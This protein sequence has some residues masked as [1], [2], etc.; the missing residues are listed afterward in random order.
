MKEEI[1]Q[2]LAQAYEDE[3]NED[4]CSYKI[5][6]D[7]SESKGTLK[8]VY[9]TDHTPKEKKYF[10]LN[11]EEDEKFFKYKKSLEEYNSTISIKKSTAPIH[12]GKGSLMQKILD[13]LAGAQRLENGALFYRFEDKELDPKI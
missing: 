13:P 12:W 3:K 4:I 1:E 2:F 9:L 7:N 11:K 10:T 5:G 6:G 8:N